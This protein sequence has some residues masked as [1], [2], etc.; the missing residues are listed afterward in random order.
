MCS[1]P[2]K[3]FWETWKPVLLCETVVSGSQMVRLGPGPIVAG[4]EAIAL[5]SEKNVLGLETLL[6]N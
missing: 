2:V 5:G 6:T 4:F 1:G 3:A